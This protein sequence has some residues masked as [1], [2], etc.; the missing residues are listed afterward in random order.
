MN[1]QQIELLQLAMILG[2]L[3]IVVSMILGFL[4]KKPRDI[5]EERYTQRIL[6]VTLDLE[7]LPPLRVPVTT[8]DALRLEA[9]TRHLTLQAYVRSLIDNRPAATNAAF[10]ELDDDER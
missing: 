5:F 9:K 4:G 8:A 2:A 3:V 1:L 6:D 7:E 10:D